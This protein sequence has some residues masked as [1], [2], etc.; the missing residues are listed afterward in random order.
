MKNPNK[1][2]VL[3]YN[4][5]IKCGYMLRGDFYIPNVYTKKLPSWFK[6]FLIKMTKCPKHC[7]GCQLKCICDANIYGRVHEKH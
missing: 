7:K 4:L 5:L 2:E 6:W 3:F 1:V